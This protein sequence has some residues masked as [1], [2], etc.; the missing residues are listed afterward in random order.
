MRM[1]FYFL[2]ATVVF[3]LLY[4]RLAPLPEARLTA[5][6]GPMEVGQHDLKG[7]FKLVH[8]ITI[9]E[10]AALA[11]LAEVA[12]AT[13]RTRAVPSARENHLQSFVTRSRIF[14]FPDITQVWVQD[15]SLHI[16][17]HLV[18]GYS[19]L[20]VNRARILN[21]TEALRGEL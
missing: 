9:D 4:I 18:Y 16:H 5:R 12:Q 2:G 1:W 7:G 10:R 20:G 11:A 21:W 14:G 13:V 3:G 19:D 6:P 15:G 17:G 8:P